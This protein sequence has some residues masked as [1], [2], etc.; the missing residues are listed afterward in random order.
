VYRG[1]GVG[2]HLVVEGVG[3]LREVGARTVIVGVAEGN[4]RALSFYRRLGFLPRTTLLAL[5]GKVEA[6]GTPSG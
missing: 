5:P 1:D 3:W 2:K 6:D 4:D